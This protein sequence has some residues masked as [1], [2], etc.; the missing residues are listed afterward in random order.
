MKENSR[1]KNSIINSSVSIITQLLTVIIN[2]IVKT[3]FIKT[4]G[5]E[6]N[7]ISGLFTNILTVLSLAELGVGE[8]ITYSL[9]KPLAENDNYKCKMLMQLYKKMYIII[10]LS[11]LPNNLSSLI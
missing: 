4:L 10:Y 8:A 9:Y 3:V 7:G 11:S 1:T 6:Y 2:F 5:N